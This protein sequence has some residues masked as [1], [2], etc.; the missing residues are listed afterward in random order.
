MSGKAGIDNFLFSFLGFEKTK[1]RRHLLLTV[2]IH[3]AGWC[4]LF[5]L[6]V[7]FYPVRIN[8]DRFI[9]RELFDKSVLVSLFYLNY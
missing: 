8:D 7:L 5:F 4:L 1:S 2:L 3:I 9:I 6:P